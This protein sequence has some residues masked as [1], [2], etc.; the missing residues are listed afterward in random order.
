MAQ[1]ITLGPNDWFEVVSTE[2]GPK[3]RLVGCSFLG[4]A[5]SGDVTNAFFPGTGNL[6]L[7]AVFNLDRGAAL[8][9]T[10]TDTGNAVGTLKSSGTNHATYDNE[11]CIAIFGDTGI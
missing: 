4:R 3:R 1:R 6:N 7:L 10:Y 2:A 8:S 9:G 5:D 11:Y